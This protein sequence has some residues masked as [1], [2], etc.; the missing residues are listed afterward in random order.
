MTAAISWNQTCADSSLKE[1][2][3]IEGEKNP[4][5]E[6]R[7]ACFSSRNCQPLTTPFCPLILSTFNRV[8][9]YGFSE[10]TVRSVNLYVLSVDPGLSSLHPATTI[11]LCSL[12]LEIEAQ[13]NLELEL[14]VCVCV[15][16]CVCVRKCVYV[17]EVGR[18]LKQHYAGS[19]TVS[20]RDTTVV[21][22]LPD[23]NYKPCPTASWQY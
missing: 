19:P 14:S 17:W 18:I 21:N 23:A 9:L 12:F 7:D 13:R 8:F 6:G 3:T 5:S 1:E 15:C 16:V 11:Y 4:Q 22:P 10:C 2:C 20:E